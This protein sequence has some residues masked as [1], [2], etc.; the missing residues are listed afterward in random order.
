MRQAFIQ[1]SIAVLCCEAAISIAVSWQV[2]GILPFLSAHALICGANVAA[3]TATHSCPDARSTFLQ[4]ALWTAIA[5]PFGAVI[6]AGLG[7]FEWSSNQPASGDFGAWL[8]DQVASR[9]MKQ[10]QLLRN[11]LLDQRLGVEGSSNIRPLCDVLAEGEQKEKLDALNVIGRRFEP[12]LSHALRLATRDGDASVRVLASTVISK[13][14]TRMT[15][16]LASM[17]EVATVTSESDAWLAL[18]EAHLD[19]SASGL[20]MPSQARDEMERALTCV[21]KALG[22][23]PRSDPIRLRFGELLVEMG[24][25]QQALQILTWGVIGAS[26]RERAR[27]LCEQARMELARTAADNR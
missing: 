6:A 24:R 10:V 19:Y 4:L 22:L 16:Q 18:G 17:R 20:V 14:Q 1:G 9:Q 27:Q 3:A 26:S 8:E 2:I 23:A 21:E 5:G 11:E 25:F 15:E 12:S 13:L 7:A